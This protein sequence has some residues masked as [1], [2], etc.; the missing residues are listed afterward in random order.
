MVMAAG[1][2]PPLV[3]PPTKGNPNGYE[4]GGE[5]DGKEE[6]LGRART[7]ARNKL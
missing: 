4:V 6:G 5:G 1:V 2:A 7:K 3:E